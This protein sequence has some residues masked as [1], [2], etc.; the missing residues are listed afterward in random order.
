MAI[1]K[2]V[3]TKYENYKNYFQKKKLTSYELFFEMFRSNLRSILLVV[4][5]CLS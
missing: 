1:T 4:S 3:H 5:T 2:M